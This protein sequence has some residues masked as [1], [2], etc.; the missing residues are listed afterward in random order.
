MPAIAGKDVDR[1]LSSPSRPRDIG[2]SSSSDDDAGAA[3]DGDYEVLDTGTPKRRSAT[4]SKATSPA[5]RKQAPTGRTSESPLS[6]RPSEHDD[7]DDSAD[8][9]SSAGYLSDATRGEQRATPNAS[10]QAG[11][12]KERAASRSYRPGSRTSQ[13]ESLGHRPSRRFSPNV[14]RHRPPSLRRRSFTVRPN[15]CKV[16][17]W[18]KSSGPSSAALALFTLQNQKSKLL[19]QVSRGIAKARAHSSQLSLPIA[20][21][22]F[23]RR[24]ARGIRARLSACGVLPPSAG[25]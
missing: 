19:L 9:R 15:G 6:R 24:P 16:D 1:R 23:G 2:S 22:G 4:S 21:G 8:E 20:K 12:K 25:L 17:S 3:G 14:Q 10:K 7:S 18:S 11:G 13:P 5:P